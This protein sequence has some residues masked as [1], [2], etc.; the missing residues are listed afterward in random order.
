MLSLRVLPLLDRGGSLKPSSA[1][2]AEINWRVNPDARHLAVVFLTRVGDGKHENAYRLA[3]EVEHPFVAFGECLAKSLA[4]WLSE[5]HG[6][7]KR[8]QRQFKGR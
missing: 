5:K 1:K 4:A 3:D 2:R 7:R 6:V 8:A